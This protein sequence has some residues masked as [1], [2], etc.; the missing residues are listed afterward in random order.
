MKALYI[1]IG[2]AATILA[3]SCAD[4]YII[5]DDHCTT[6]HETMVSITLDPMAYSDLGSRSVSPDLVDEGN[7]SNNSISDLWLVEFDNKGK[8]IGSPR[9]FNDPSSMTAVSVIIPESDGVEYTLVAIA[10]TG[11]DLLLSRLAA[12]TEIA[13]LWKLS[14]DF[15]DE[16]YGYTKQENS[17]KGRLVMNGVQKLNSKTSE[18]KITMLRNVA[19]ISVDITCKGTSGVNLKKVRLCKVPVKIG[20]VDQLVGEA[21]ASMAYNATTINLPFDEWMPESANGDSKMSL[22]YYVPRNMQ[23][24]SDSDNPYNKGKYAPAAATYLEIIASDATD[25]TALRYRFYLGKD[26]IKNFDVEPNY[27]Y[28]LPI[29]IS[30]KGDAALDARVESFGSSELSVSSNS[31]ILPYDNDSQVYT[32][33]IIS[34]DRVNYFWTHDNVKDNEKNKYIIHQTTNWVA[35]VIWQDTDKDIFHF[36]NKDGSDL[37]SAPHFFHGS[38]TDAGITVRATG[39]GAGNVLIGIRKDSPDWDEATDG[40]MWSWHL[41]IS[42]YN[43]ICNAF[44]TETTFNRPVDGG[45][46]HRYDS[47]YWKNNVPSMVYIMDRNFGAVTADEIPGD[48]PKDSRHKY[49]GLYYNFGRK[50]PFPLVGTKLYK[51]NEN[52]DIANSPTVNTASIKIARTGEMSLENSVKH[53][54]WNLTGTNSWLA[55]IIFYDWSLSSPDLSWN[56]WERVHGKSLFDPTPQG[57]AIPLADHCPKIENFTDAPWSG[58]GLYLR[59][60]NLAEN[61]GDN[62]AYFPKTDYQR[63]GG[64]ATSANYEGATIMVNTPSNAYTNFYAWLIDRWCSNPLQCKKNNS[65]ARRYQAPTRLVRDPS[66]D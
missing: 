57:W 59:L 64:L 47:D 42:E 58:S 53:P 35:Q 25:G 13:D 26:M 34:L 20:Y 38:G 10:N 32:K 12:C 28:H 54:N 45:H 66:Q 11:D 5:G 6:G 61:S 62:L 39:N 14:Y 4:D 56:D 40:Y 43:P 65:I 41:W 44:I 9:Y 33:A 21:G 52:S 63:D 22:L 30:S 27:H 3:P 48:I 23:G 18:I 8:Q 17:E 24:E 49:F 46:V 36:C 37:A 55:N 29:I 51:Y 31:Y 2:V 7:G 19:K 15:F 16:T 50:D 1:L 60:N